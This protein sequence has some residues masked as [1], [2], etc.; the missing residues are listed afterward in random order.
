MSALPLKA[1]IDPRRRNV[2]FGPEADICT[3]DPEV[4]AAAV[5]A[6]CATHRRIAAPLVVWIAVAAVR[7]R[8]C[9]CRHPA[10]GPR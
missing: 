5:L 4:S 9:L 1:D 7:S 3:T 8:L 2:C 10:R 6:P